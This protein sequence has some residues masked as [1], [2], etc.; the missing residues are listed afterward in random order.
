MKRTTYSQ[1]L[2]DVTAR[3]PKGAAADIAVEDIVQLKMQNTYDTHLDIAREM[4]SV[5][6]ADMAAYDQDTSKFTQSL[7]C[8]S[9]FHAQQKIKGRQADEGHC[10]GRLHLSLWLDGRRSAQHLGAS[11]GSVDA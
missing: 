11:A 8:W 1:T 2:A 10:Q 7:G 9:G 4:A 3:L 6:R 5:M